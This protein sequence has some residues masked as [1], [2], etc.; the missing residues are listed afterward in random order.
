MS[1]RRRDATN[2]ARFTHEWDVIEE[3]GA[4]RFVECDEQ[5]VPVNEKRYADFRAAEALGEL[6]Y[7]GIR[8]HEPGREAAALDRASDS[9]GTQSGRSYATT[10]LDGARASGQS[11]GGDM[12][13]YRDS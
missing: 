6:S 9:D 5:G 4:G 8:R 1:M 11:L 10:V 2:T 12:A 13:L 7:R 3:P